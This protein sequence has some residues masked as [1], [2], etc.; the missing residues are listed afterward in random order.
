M[1]ERAMIKAFLFDKDG[2]IIDFEHTWHWALTRLFNRMKMECTLSPQ[3][4]NALK[5][6]SGLRPA[7]FDCESIIQRLSAPA[8]VEIW[9]R[10]IWSTGIRESPEALPPVDLLR[11]EMRVR[12]R[13]AAVAAGN[14]AQALPGVAQML[15]ELTTRGYPLGVATAD[16]EESAERALTRTGLHKYF[17]FI[18][19]DGGGYHPKPNP[20]M[21]MAFCRQVDVRPEELLVVGDSTTD[22]AFAHNAGA[23]FAGLITPYNCFAHEPSPEAV[24]LRG[25]EELIDL[26]DGTTTR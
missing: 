19:G 20:D 11:R 23:R 17:S 15:A 18:G 3:V 9:L 12:L 22:F 21:A 26:S 16:S 24:F 2:T 4:I 1:I 8:I 6:V 14:N 10:T 5:A 25:P 13:E 7:G